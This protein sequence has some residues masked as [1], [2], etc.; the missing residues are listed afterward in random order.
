MRRG[1]VILFD[2]HF[3]I[4]YYAHDIAGGKDIPLPNRVHGWML[5]KLY[6]RPDVVIML[7]APAEVLFSRKGEGT[8]ELLELRRQEYKNIQ[9]VISDFYIVDATQTPEEVTL[10]VMDIVE[11]FYEKSQ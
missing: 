5:K 2:R 9:T 8:I 4:D 6:P 7:D 10:Q 3:F 1:N 11:S